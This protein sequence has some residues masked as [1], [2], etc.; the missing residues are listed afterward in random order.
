MILGAGA[1]VVGFVV[2]RR[3]RAQGRQLQ[4]VKEA[5]RE[6]LVAL[7]DDVAG[8]E[9]DV[10]RDPDAKADYLAAL[11]QYDGASRAFDRARTPARSSSR[12]PARST[13][14]AT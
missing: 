2:I 12:L 10:E 13:K 1:A 9:D 4:E 14:A 3:R 8:L 11:E 7:A 6:D 5:A